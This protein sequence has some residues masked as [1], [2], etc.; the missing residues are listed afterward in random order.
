VI[1]G[2]DRFDG[3]HV[4][5]F[6]PQSASR[7]A[8]VRNLFVVAV[9]VTAALGARYTE[10]TAPAAADPRVGINA[11]ALRLPAA[12]RGQ[13]RRRTAIRP[14]RSGRPPGNRCC[15]RSR[16]RRRPIDFRCR[17]GHIRGDPIVI[18]ECEI[19][20]ALRRRELAEP[21]AALSQGRARMACVCRPLQ[22]GVTIDSK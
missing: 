15:R 18:V 6:P 1:S 21:A 9:F 14:Q 13:H 12:R 17:N 8:G 10:A 3:Y 22:G 4:E 2:D 19:A 5:V 20:L 11:D 7:H 16:V